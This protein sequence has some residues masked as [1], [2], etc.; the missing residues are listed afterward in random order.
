MIVA[1]QAQPGATTPESKMLGPLEEVVVLDNEADDGVLRH[2]ELVLHGRA[3]G[4]RLPW[5]RF[6]RVSVL[7][8]A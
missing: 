1:Q 7:L 3:L 2:G 8:T 6:P 4:P 5:K